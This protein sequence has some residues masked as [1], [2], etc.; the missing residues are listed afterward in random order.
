MSSDSGESVYSQTSAR[1][2]KMCKKSG[3]GS[4]VPE[5]ADIFRVG[6]RIPPFWPEKPAIWFAQIEG[7][8]AISRITEDTTKFYY[9]IAQ[10]DNLYASE[11]ED[12][13]TSPPETNKYEKLKSELIKRLSVSRENNVKQLLMHEEL[14]DRKPSQFLRHLQH[15]A[16][17]TVP[18]DFLKT[19]WTSRL[20]SS[21][22]TIIASQPTLPIEALADLADRINDIAPS[23]PQIATT[24][25]PESAFDT[26]ARQIA[27]LTRQ[28]S[29]LSAK[30]NL[31]H[32]SRQRSRRSSRHRSPSPAS[33]SHSSHRKYPI[34]WYHHKFGDNA[35]KCNRPCN[36]KSGNATGS[37]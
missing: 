10:L 15:L 20:P 18:E 2:R 3:R 19:I 8:F 1:T 26:M 4:T 23:N 14:G 34:C 13:I 22:Q 27:E 16:G 33:Q 5:T 12:I 9:V 35:T 31:R 6:V 7:Q 37:R 29:E 25:R 24:S 11:V 30:V 28:V 17:P 32:S 36:F 21:M